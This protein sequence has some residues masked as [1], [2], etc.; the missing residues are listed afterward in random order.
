MMGDG[1]VQRWLSTICEVEYNDKQTWHYLID[2]LERDLK[3]QQLETS[4]KTK[5]RSKHL[6]KK[7]MLED[8]TVISLVTQ[9]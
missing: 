6:K 9:V 4:Q 2:F 3:V 1:R 7:G 5:D 8:I